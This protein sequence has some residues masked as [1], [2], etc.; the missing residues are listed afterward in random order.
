MGSRDGG[1]D[2]RRAGRV[3]LPT[4]WANRR[5]RRGR[6]RWTPR[7]LRFPLDAPPRP[8]RE[9]VGVDFAGAA[10]VADGSLPVRLTRAQPT[11]SPR[12]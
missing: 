7:C 9:M 10:L 4:L 1:R 11:S 12:I 5:S 6:R 2:L 3:A 8:A